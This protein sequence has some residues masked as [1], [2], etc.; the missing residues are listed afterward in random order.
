[1]VRLGAG[2]R[3][4]AF[5]G[6]LFL[7]F[8]VALH[9]PA[10]A[11]TNL[12]HVPNNAALKALAAGSVS[13]VRRDGFATA[14]DGGAAIYYW[15]GTACTLTHTVGGIVLPG[16]DG[17]QV[18]PTVG[19]GCWIADI[20]A[21]TDIRLWG[22]IGG[23]DDTAIWT[24][25][26]TAIATGLKTTLLCSGATS[27]N[28]WHPNHIAYLRGNGSCVFNA[29]AT[30]TTG[31]T[32]IDYNG[33][34]PITIENIKF[35]CPIF[36]PDTWATPVC[37]KAIRIG[38]TTVAVSQ[39]KL[40]DISCVGGQQCINALGV[41]YI[42]IENFWIDRPYG[43]GISIVMAGSGGLGALYGNSQHIRLAHGWCRG[44]GGYCFTIDSLAT[45]PTVAMR[46][47]NV[48]DVHA[49]FGGF[50][51]EK[52]CFDVVGSEFSQAHIEVFGIN[53]RDGGAEIK[54]SPSDTTTGIPHYWYGVDANVVY[55]SN[56]D[57]GQG[58]AINFEQDNSTPDLQ[59]RHRV[60]SF[61][62]WLP[63]GAWQPKTYYD[64]GN[65][66][67]AGGYTF[68]VLAPGMSAL[69]GSG[70]TP[71]GAGHAPATPARASRPTTGSS[72]FACRRRRRRP[73]TSSAPT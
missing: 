1:M 70:P 4:L 32:L 5:I 44:T 14:G 72:G 62:T 35:V 15:T 22:V 13:A 60:R 52:Y 31:G 19:T 67:T 20:G 24:V 6:I 36:D 42:D 17:Y 46:D 43:D 26:D 50:I 7:T 39:A 63:P 3:R 34:G 51:A 56:W 54:G 12:V 9:A 69:T 47:L 37:N 11:Q 21:E 23:S 18:A 57:A 38:S 64:V 71:P 33:P 53:C 68:A 59:G 10:G 25:A 40:R 61:T 2:I 66:V 8:A 30:V 41:E 45:S 55:E 65:V 29:A 73:L 28:G 48:V 27:V 58:V 16:D 49:D